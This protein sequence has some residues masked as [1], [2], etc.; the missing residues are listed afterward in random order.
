MVI[1]DG[2]VRVSRIAGREGE[3]YMSPDIEKDA[4]IAR[5]AEYKGVTIGEWKIRRGSVGR[6]RRTG[7]S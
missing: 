3:S 4:A 5:W 6:E 2:Y 7:P 1:M